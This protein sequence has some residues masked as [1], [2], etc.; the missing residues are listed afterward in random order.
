L[1]RKSSYHHAFFKVLSFV[2][3][4]GAEFDVSDR[5]LASSLSGSSKAHEEYKK[6][7]NY[8]SL[9]R[10]DRNAIDWHQ[11]FENVVSSIGVVDPEKTVKE[12]GK[13]EPKSELYQLCIAQAIEEYGS[14][15][16]AIQPHIE[17]LEEFSKRPFQCG[18]S[19]SFG[20]RD[21]T[22]G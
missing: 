15:P 9:T 16:N 7:N 14:L 11:N 21:A 22:L 19:G 6:F 12:L 2:S 20:H 5:K 13:I 1:G 4:S 18:A 3:E 17:A 10:I 8:S